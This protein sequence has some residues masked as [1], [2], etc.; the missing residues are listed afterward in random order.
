MFTE[1]DGIKLR[2]EQ[3]DRLLVDLNREAKQLMARLRE[4]DASGENPHEVSLKPEDRDTLKSSIDETLEALQSR[5]KRPVN[6]ND[7][8]KKELASHKALIDEL[9]DLLS[10]K[11]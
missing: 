2:L 4:L 1:R 8:K 9:S 10:K 5:S 11:K 6:V 3:I 7:E